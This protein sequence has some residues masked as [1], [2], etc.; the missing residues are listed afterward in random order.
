MG[1]E[2]LLEYFSEYPATKARHSYGPQGHRGI[3][4][5]IFEATAVGY[6]EAVRLN[7]HFEVSSRDRTA[8]HKNKV[9]FYPGGQRQLYGYM[10][11]KHDMEDFNK[12]SQ[13]ALSICVGRLCMSWIFFS[14]RVNGAGDLLLISHWLLSFIN[15]PKCL[16]KSKLKYEVRSYQEMVVKQMKQMSDDNQQLIYFKD[17][18]IK[19]QKKTKAAEQFVEIISEKL[20]NTKVE[21]QVIKLRTQKHH[22]Q[23]KEEVC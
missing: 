20:R 15:F 21:N 5:L 9:P 13:G 1:N 11:E 3:S 18:V 19:E 7:E 17:K 8:W 4:M 14:F 12:H 2:D 6:V 16:G 10:A 22:E 23:N